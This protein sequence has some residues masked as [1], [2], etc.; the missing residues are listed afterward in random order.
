MSKDNTKK[1]QVDLPDA[2]EL[3]EEAYKK[4]KHDRCE[5]RIEYKNT[6]YDVCANKRDMQDVDADK[7][8]E[9]LTRVNRLENKIYHG[10]EQ[11]LDAD[12]FRI[13][14]TNVN[15]QANSISDTSRRF[16]KK[17]LLE[18]LRRK[19]SDGEGFS[20]QSLGYASGS[21]FSCAASTR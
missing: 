16:D 5:T 6:K 9:V 17:D 20:W 4:L 3:D 2:D 11:Q 1:R 19:F 14:S 7:F 10:R 13:M 18:S 8:Q 15:T 21:I 12:L